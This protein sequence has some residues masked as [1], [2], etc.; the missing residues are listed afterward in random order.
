MYDNVSKPI[1]IYNHT[2]QT[3]LDHDTQTHT[4]G[5]SNRLIG[6]DGVI[7]AAENQD[8]LVAL[9]DGAS[10][11][12]GDV[13]RLCF[14]AS[15][16]HADCDA[17]FRCENN[18]TEKCNAALSNFAV[19]A[20]INTYNKSSVKNFYNN[21]KS[22]YERGLNPKF[23]D[24]SSGNEVT[25]NSENRM[26]NNGNRMNNSYVCVKNHAITPHNQANC[27]GQWTLLTAFYFNMTVILIRLIN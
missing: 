6:P 21:N 25:H 18:W 27:T 20:S 16:S 9:I 13:N 4:H 1:S 7:P 15:S 10:A 3:F 19:S 11:L 2:Q 14:T 22:K 12:D 23:V 5:R 17:N 24:P 26:A 8:F